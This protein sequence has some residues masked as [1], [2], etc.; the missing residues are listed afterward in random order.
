MNRHQALFIFCFPIAF[1]KW[2]HTGIPS[3]SPTS[4]YQKKHVMNTNPDSII[5]FPSTI[6]SSPLPNVKN[7]VN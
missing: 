1:V 6:S 7:K 4:S 2:I 5:Y 3:T